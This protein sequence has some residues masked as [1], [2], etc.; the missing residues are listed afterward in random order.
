MK[1]TLVLIIAA[2]FV[3]C[4]EKP[5][6]NT[7][8]VGTMAGPETELVEVAQNLLQEKHG[9]T[10]KIVEFS[11]Y[12]L[13]N[14]ALQDGTL[15]VNI[16]QHLPYLEDA[17]KAHHYEL[18]VVGKTFLY[19]AAIYSNK[20]K[21][22]KELKSGAI[23]AIP[24]D[25]SNEARALLLLQDAGLIRLK[26]KRSASLFDIK[27]NSKHYQFRELDAAQL[28]RVLP[29]V[30]IAVINTNFAIPAG[31]HPNR[32]ALFTESKTSPYANLIVIRKSS[33]KKAQIQLLVDALHTEE[34]KDK[35]K[36]LFS[37]AAIPAW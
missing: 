6:P 20:I 16:F 13:P 28:S 11:D 37:D 15:D 8:I 29:D 31:L 26:T 32:N 30:D 22:L 27:R 18:E 24:N 14:A 4:T 12:N 1:V 5:N 36:T 33:P 9:L 35:A 3:A 2:L 21:S 17:I 25:P 34:V 23:I 10:V 7:L 19:P